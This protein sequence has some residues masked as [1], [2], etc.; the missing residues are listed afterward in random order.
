M[1][2]PRQI[3]QDPLK[4]YGLGL[5][6]IR[7]MIGKQ[8]S[9]FAEEGP[10]ST[11]IKSVEQEFS[12]DPLSGLNR[13]EAIDY[14]ESLGINTK[15]PSG[16][17]EQLVSRA[18]KRPEEIFTSEIQSLQPDVSDFSEFAKSYSDVMS[19]IQPN[20][21]SESQEKFTENAN[22][23]ED[24]PNNSAAFDESALD[25]I[26]ATIAGAEIPSYENSGDA[27][28]AGQAGASTDSAILTEGKITQ[29][30]A[31]EGFLSAMDDFFEASRGAGPEMPEKRT[32]E[33]YKKVFSEA[34]G[35][36]TSGEV[37]KSD[38]LMA[39]G[40]ALMQNK[41]GKGFN[42][43][44]MLQSVGSAGDK[45]MPA[46]QKAKDRARQGALAG[47][48]YALQT[49]SA[50]K[51]TR[52]AN[53]EKMMNRG[54][55]WFYEKGKPGAAFEGFDKGQFENLNKYELNQLIND[56]EFSKKYDFINASDRFSILE[57][58]A[59][60]LDLGDEWTNDLKNVS[61]IG[62]KADEL[63]SALVVAGHPADANYG[64]KASARYKLGESEEGVVRRFGDYQNEIVRNEEKL[65]LLIANIQ[66]GITLPEQ[67]FSKVQQLGK[68][69][70]MSVDTS[71][72]ASAQQSL[73]NIAIDNVLEILKESGRTISEG[74]RK[75]VEKRVGNIDMSLAGS[76]P[77][78]VLNQV[79]YVYDMVV[80]KPQKD[81]D[82]ALKGFEDNFGYSIS[83]GSNQKSDK[84]TQ[85]EL[86]AMNAANNTNLTM[87]DF[88]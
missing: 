44:K 30:Q 28:A 59:E 84:P 83:G 24:M 22:R 2:D 72:V 61:L 1:A 57:K 27:M 48:K 75:R 25:Q 76:N 69:L 17:F 60:G 68:S 18:N 46:L 70:G 33:E 23:I 88:K 85:A 79:K 10:S 35:I 11:G 8:R 6:G 21:V 63:P 16:A 29:K 53:E 4:A 9:P 13:E 55:Y 12:D 54:K 87:A 47:G 43:G 14:I 45:A 5:G 50:D 67:L 34:T 7:S 49:Q 78:L 32:I 36:D 20:A 3:Y 52:A 71:S 39:F 80:T 42:V 40:L 73:A 19:A 77:E 64:G 41:A 65:S 31:D 86:D 66:E 81:L 51:A 56:P 37:D 38:A 74:E 15:N 58:R 62:G 82:N 26:A